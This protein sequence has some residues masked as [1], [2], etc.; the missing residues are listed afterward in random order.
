MYFYN[1][2]S[3]LIKLV[4]QTCYDPGSV[5]RTII[6]WPLAAPSLLRG[7]CPSPIEVCMREYISG[8]WSG[9]SQRGRAAVTIV[10]ALVILGAFYLALVNSAAF[11]SV[12]EALDRLIP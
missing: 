10:I 12:T 11:S 6:H 3:P 1:F 5:G 8:F 7:L 4:A 2:V 9:L